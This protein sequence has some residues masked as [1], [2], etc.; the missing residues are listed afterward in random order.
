VRRRFEYDGGTWD[1]ELTG[2]GG[3]GCRAHTLE[4]VFRCV[5]T[6]ET[7]PARIVPAGDERL[8][9]AVLVAALAAARAAS[10]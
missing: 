2:T 6:G 9:D 5:S 8:T 7:V 10:G 4:V 3:A 1:V